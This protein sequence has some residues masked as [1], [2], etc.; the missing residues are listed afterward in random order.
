MGYLLWR[1]L[2]E[3]SCRVLS[4][5]SDDQLKAPQQ[6]RMTLQLF[7]TTFIFFSSTT[8]RK[9]SYILV[10]CHTNQQ[11]YLQNIRSILWNAQPMHMLYQKCPNTSATPYL[12]RSRL[13]YKWIISADWQLTLL[14][15]RTQAADYGL[16]RYAS[17]L[18]WFLTIVLSIGRRYRAILVFLRQTVNEIQ[19]SFDTPSSCGLAIGDALRALL[20]SRCH[21]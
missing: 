16:Q 1:R 4:S 21:M 8:Q 2:D 12:A 11:N 19:S 10:A 9:Q 5:I 14:S 6:F 15:S 18:R 17:L 20:L 7:Q 13:F 3:S